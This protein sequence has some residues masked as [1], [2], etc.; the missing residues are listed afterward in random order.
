VLGLPPTPP[1][2]P[3]PSRGPRGAPAITPVAILFSTLQDA[4]ALWVKLSALEYFEL[5]NEVWAEL[6]RIFRRHAGLPGR[7][8]DEGLVCY[9]LPQ[10]EG[11]HLWNALTAA[12]EAR[13]T[14]AISA[15]AGSS[16]RAGISSCA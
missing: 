5:V 13:D 14:M 8:P 10:R 3:G 1:D 7:H 15:A 9:F 12:R 6:D 16:A 2:A 11:S 4:P